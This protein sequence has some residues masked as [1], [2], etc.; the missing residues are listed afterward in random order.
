MSN[1]D[2]KSILV[3]DDDISTAGL[4]AFAV[5]QAQIAAGENLPS[6]GGVFFSVADRDKAAGLAAARAYSDLGFEIIATAGTAA[7]LVKPP[8]G[9]AGPGTGADVGPGRGPG[10]E[11][12]CGRGTAG[13]SPGTASG[14]LVGPDLAL[15]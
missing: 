2:K 8:G 14:R 12:G 4:C 10:I 13:G 3:I 7:A 15:R 6:S 9:G 5:S 11:P 1:N